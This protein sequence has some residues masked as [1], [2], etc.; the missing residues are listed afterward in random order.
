MTLET[1]NPKPMISICTACTP[2]YPVLEL[3]PRLAAAGYDGIELGVK[4]HQADPAQPPN[5]WK[6]N[7]A[8]ISV[9]ALEALLPELEAGLQQHGLRL[10]AIGSYHQAHELVTH[11]RLAVIARRL[12]CGII[13]ATIPGHDAKE[14]YAAQLA[15]Q[16]S[17]WRELAALG[18]GEGVRFAIELHD[19]S[20]TASASAAMRILEDLPVA[21]CGVILDAANTVYEGNEAIPMLIDI[22]GRH[23]AH[24]HVKQRTFRRRDTPDRASLLDLPIT[25]LSEPGDVPWLAIVALLRAAGYAGWWSV[26]DFTRLDQPDDRLRTDAVWIKALLGDGS[27]S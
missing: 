6:N 16:R 21:G 23:L 2:W 17:A 13:R 14:G 25:P 18:A 11:R 24:V 26:E 20:L 10:A 9:D 22:L 5:C 7:H 3:L 8:V 27:V 15:A 4:P 12:G 1:R 19:H